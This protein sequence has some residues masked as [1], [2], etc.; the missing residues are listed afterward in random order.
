MKEEEKSKE[1]PKEEII[2]DLTKPEPKKR[3]CGCK[4]KNK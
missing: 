3:G 2:V 1:T 4:N